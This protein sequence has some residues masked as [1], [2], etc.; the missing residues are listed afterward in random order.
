[1]R[2]QQN[3]PHP[4]TRDALDKPSKVCYYADIEMRRRET[5]LI[6]VIFPA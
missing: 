1:M 5:R 2:L 3:L 4:A 6:F